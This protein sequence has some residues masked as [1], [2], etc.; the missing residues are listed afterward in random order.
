MIGLNILSFV[1]F[2]ILMLLQNIC[3]A[4][5][6]VSAGWGCSEADNLT[7]ENSFKANLDNL[8]NQLAANGPNTN[9]ADCTNQSIAVAVQDCLKSNTV[10]VWCTCCYLRYSDQPIFSVG[11]KSSAAIYNS[12]D[13]DNPAVESQGFNFMKGLAAVAANQTL[14]FQA[15]VLDVGQSGKRGWEIYGHSCSMWYHDYQFYFSISTS[16]NGGARRSSL[17]GVTIDIT[18]VVLEF[19]LVL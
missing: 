16:S 3:L 1:L 10:K 7:S 19:V 2:I 17:R 18:M 4:N 9:C 12:T 15:G 5:N 11:D 6:N 14:M 8:L 13:S